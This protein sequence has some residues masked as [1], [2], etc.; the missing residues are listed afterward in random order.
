MDK[1]LYL[2]SSK[3]CNM[4]CITES[5]KYT[6]EVI[7]KQGLTKTEIAI[8][9]GKHKSIIGREISQNADARNGV[10]KSPLASNKT[11]KRHNYKTPIFVMEKLLFNSEAAFMG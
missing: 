2:S 9:I 6:I 4:S 8:T 11:R 3:S 7:L 10:Y 5:Q 1:N